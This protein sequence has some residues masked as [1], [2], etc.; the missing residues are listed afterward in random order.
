LG[1]IGDATHNTVGGGGISFSVWVNA[2]M[3]SSNMQTSWNGLF[4][5]WTGTPQFEALELE[6]P[7]PF[8]PANNYSPASNFVKKTSALTTTL[9]TGL[10]PSGDFGGRWNHWAFVKEPSS[11]K[12][13]INGTL[14]AS[15][16]ANGLTGDPNVGVYGPLCADPNVTAFRIGTRG[17]NWGMWNGY[18]QDFQMYDYALSA[19]EAAWLATDGSGHVFLPLVSPANINTDGSVDPLHDINQIVNFGDLAIMGKQWHTTILWP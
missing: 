9:G 3:T 2:D 12:I 4:G 14:V 11:M 6:C 5:I 13:Y 17:G 1:F 18:I 10:R 19:G 16:D 7:I 8:M 15:R